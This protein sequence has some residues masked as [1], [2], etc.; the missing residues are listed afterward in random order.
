M[1]ALRE[2]LFR[3]QCLFLLAA[4]FAITANLAAGQPRSNRSH[5]AIPGQL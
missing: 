4:V 5:A 2:N 3:A 1:N